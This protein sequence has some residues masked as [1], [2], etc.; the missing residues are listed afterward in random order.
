MVSMIFH[1][2]GSDRCGFAPRQTEIYQFLSLCFELQGPTG[3]LPLRYGG[4]REFDV[5]RTALHDHVVIMI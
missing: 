5:D 1:D 3:M 2:V 4:C